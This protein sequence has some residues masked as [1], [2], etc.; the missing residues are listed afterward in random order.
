MTRPPAAPVGR[1]SLLNRIDLYA[2]A[3]REKYAE[4]KWLQSAT[5]G[6]AL[7]EQVTPLLPLLSEWAK[8]RAELADSQG[9]VKQQRYAKACEA[10][11]TV[12]AG[13]GSP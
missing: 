9:E 6:C 8:A 3:T 12:L 13:T 11:F 4:G 10:L 7:A 2:K 1:A 5:R